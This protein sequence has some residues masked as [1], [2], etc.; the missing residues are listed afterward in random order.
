MEREILGSVAAIVES[1]DT[2]LM[3]IVALIITIIL[4]GTAKYWV[5]YATEE[6]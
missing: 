3:F 2:W 6:K 5:Y 4:F 1:R